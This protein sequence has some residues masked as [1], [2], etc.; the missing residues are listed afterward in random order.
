M[1]ELVFVSRRELTEPR[2]PELA[3]YLAQFCLEIP[4]RSRRC[5]GG[6]EVFGNEPELLSTTRALDVWAC[7]TTAQRPTSPLAL[8]ELAA[9]LGLLLEY[10][11]DIDRDGKV[12][13]VNGAVGNR[14]TISITRV[15]TNPFNGL[16]AGSVMPC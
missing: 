6:P 16:A 8:C 12:S 7:Q 1:A 10:M 11:Q 13:G 5:R 2:H 3:H 4:A 9:A 14:S 15:P